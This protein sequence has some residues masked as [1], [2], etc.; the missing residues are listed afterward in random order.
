MY[1]TIAGVSKK[2]GAAYFEDHGFDAFKEGT[3]ISNSGHLIAFYNESPK[4][5]ITVN[6]CRILTASNI[7]LINQD[8]TIGLTD[9]YKRLLADQAKNILHKY[10]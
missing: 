5:Y 4:H 7:A 6:G 2:A 8:Y 9:D 3:A 10:M 1:C